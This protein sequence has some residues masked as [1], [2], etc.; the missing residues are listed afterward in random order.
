SGIVSGLDVVADNGLPNAPTVRVG[1]G[2]AVNRLGQPL[3]LP[4]DLLL[5]LA[6]QQDQADLAAGLF[7]DC[8]RPSSGTVALGRGLYI[9]AMTPA[10]GYQERVPLVRFNEPGRADGCGDR[11]AVEGV[12]FR[13]VN[14][15]LTDTDLFAAALSAQL[16]EYVNDNTDVIVSHSRLQNIVAHLFFG[17]ER[18]QL[19][20]IEALPSVDVLTAP[21][22]SLF[23]KVYEQ[24][25]LDECDV[26]L[27]LLFWT[28]AGL[29]FI[30]MWAVRRRVE[31]YTPSD[32]VG[33]C[34]ATR[35]AMLH[36]FLAQIA[37]LEQALTPAERATT[38]LVDY[39][40][41]LPPAAL[42]PG[43]ASGF[44]IETLFSGRVHGRYV[45]VAPGVLQA[46]IEASLA[47]KP[48]DPAD[49]VPIYLFAAAEP[50]TEI[51][52][53]ASAYLLF[54][55]R[56]LL[57][58]F[59]V[60]LLLQ[61]GFNQL[62]AATLGTL[63]QETVDAYR[64]I[65]TIVLINFADRAT[66]LTNVDQLGLL[67][68][69]QVIGFVQ[70]ILARATAA[71][72]TQD[73]AIGQFLQLAHAQ[74][75]FTTTYTTIVL[76][77]DGVDRRTGIRYTESFRQM[78]GAI[79]ELLNRTTTS[80]GVTGLFRALAQ[81]SLFDAT[82]TQ[83]SINQ[84]LQL[85]TDGTPRGTLDIRLV[86]LSSTVINPGD[87]IDFIFAIEART[88]LAETYQV[89]PTVDADVAQAAWSSALQ[90]LTIDRLPLSPPT[91]RIEPN[92]TTVVV[93]QIQGVPPGTA[94]SDVRL[95]LSATSQRNPFELQGASGV[96]SFTVGS[97]IVDPAPDIDMVRTSVE[98]SA[99]VTADG[100]VLINPGGGGA[101]LFI[102]TTF[103]LPGIYHVTISPPEG[104]IDNWT[105]QILSPPNLPDG[106]PGY[107]L[108]TA[109]LP[110]PRVQFIQIGLLPSAAAALT[111]LTV[112][113]ADA[114]DESHFKEYVQRVGLG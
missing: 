105:R 18:D 96:Q 73:D 94:D 89:V 54:A 8:G 82:V 49:T 67:A 11:Y 41:L 56:Q 22:M 43:T 16:I 57:M 103:E 37:R 70:G 69:Q 44:D 42:V 6:R 64:R 91:V 75:H 107:N 66:L 55:S 53:T 58:H 106:T 72:L 79:N 12:Q 29:Q 97:E 33:P 36:Q 14:L 87:V 114:N 3:E 100:T 104:D 85:Q 88:N 40:A 23:E 9:L 17:V 109:P 112:R 32:R 13:L 21:T 84:R 113:V 110:S 61:R 83:R 111:N 52:E 45:V 35:E 5:D 1:K 99:T 30:D 59:Q 27:A 48:I 62:D 31:Q 92:E 10:S 78:I 95:S 77:R 50:A 47:F 20:L 86:E 102:Q 81:Y 76:N 39:F 90:L 80:A 19:Q 65:E 63:W 46:I 26:P 108:G 60:P 15:D 51:I 4:Q 68:L 25:V 74:Q 93:L 34:R 7:A 71:A 2:L 24:A 38:A 28:P 101:V 98:G